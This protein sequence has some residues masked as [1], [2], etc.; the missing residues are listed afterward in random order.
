VLGVEPP[1]VDFRDVGDEIGLDAA[2]PT[3]EVVEPAKQL[4]VRERLKWS[5]EWHATKVG[6]TMDRPGPAA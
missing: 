3:R 2:L 5:V 1:P 4:V 6:P